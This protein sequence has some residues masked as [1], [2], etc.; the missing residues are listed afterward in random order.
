MEGE[1]AFQ[2]AMYGHFRIEEPR[3]QNPSYLPKIR[4][5]PGY[6]PQVPGKPVGR[7]SRPKTS[8]PVQYTGFISG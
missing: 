6:H 5:T 1:Y 7:L 2:G 3:A 8:N 4:E